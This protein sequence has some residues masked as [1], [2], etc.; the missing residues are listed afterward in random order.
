MFLSV[1]PGGEVRGP[2]FTPDDRTFFVAVQHSGEGK[3]APF[4]NPLSRFPDYKPDMPLRSRVVA[5]YHANGSKVGIS[6]QYP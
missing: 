2:T 6:P 5:I 3:R 1:L 4:V